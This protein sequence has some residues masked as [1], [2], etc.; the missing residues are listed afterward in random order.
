MYGGF[1]SIL[2]CM[3][4]ISIDVY[5]AKTWIYLLVLLVYQ[6]VLCKNIVDI[7]IGLTSVYGAKTLWILVY[8]LV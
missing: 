6:C 8:L 7:S 1:T 4:D 5:G 2:V 3:V